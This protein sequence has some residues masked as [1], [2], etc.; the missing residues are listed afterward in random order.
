[1]TRKENLYFQEVIADEKKLKPISGETIRQIRAESKGG[2]TTIF[3]ETDNLVLILGANDLGAWFK[4][5]KEKE[6]K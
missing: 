6:L 5:I 4:E 1:M 2:D 3:I